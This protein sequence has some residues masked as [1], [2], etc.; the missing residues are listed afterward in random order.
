MIQAV[1]ITDYSDELEY[2]REGKVNFDIRDCRGGINH[3]VCVGEG[4]N[5]ERAVL[6][7]YVQEDGTIGKS[8]YYFGLEERAAVYEYSSADLEKLEEYGTKR[9]KDLQNYR[10][11]DVTVDDVDLEIGDIVGGYEEITGTR[12]QKPVTR[13]IIKMKRGKITID[14]EV[15]G[16]D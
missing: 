4:Q 14:Y 13:K 11:I 12:L 1:P 3:L 8:Q 16:D 7:L 9:M 10:S 2:S 5:E 15:K 6:H